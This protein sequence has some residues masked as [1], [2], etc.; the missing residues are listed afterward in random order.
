MD[1]SDKRHTLAAFSAGKKPGTKTSGI[2]E[3][4]QPVWK[5]QKVEES[6]ALAGIAIPHRSACSLDTIPTELHWL[7][8]IH[9]S[10]K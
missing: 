5:F 1:V 4:P 2:R 10:K 6:L 9:L 7:I 8:N 3:G